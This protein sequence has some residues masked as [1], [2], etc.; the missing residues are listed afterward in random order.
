MNLS[1]HNQCSMCETTR[2]AIA[3]TSRKRSRGDSEGFRG[4]GFDAA[5]VQRLI[6]EDLANRNYESTTTATSTPSAATYTH[7]NL[8]DFSSSL[9]KRIIPYVPVNTLTSL[10]VATKSWRGVADDFITG[11][12]KNGGAMVVG[13]MN[14]R[15]PYLPWWKEKREQVT[16]VLFLHNI[17]NIGNFAC[18]NAI[19]LV[20]VEIP[21]GVVSIGAQAFE[22]CRSLTRVSSEDVKID[23]LQCLRWLLQS[24][25]C[26]SPP[27]A[28][29]RIR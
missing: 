28:T 14:G 17:T 4:E 27:Y 20:V 8:D 26:R 18:I 7:S 21:E 10:R 29:S 1:Q 12:V 25:K 3:Q 16:Q 9:L 6:F 19:N 22:D 11:C 23:W 5:E 2:Y 13:E 24:R 15:S